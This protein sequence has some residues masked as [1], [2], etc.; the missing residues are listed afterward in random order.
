MSRRCIVLSAMLLACLGAGC[1]MTTTPPQSNL[2]PKQWT[3][4]QSDEQGTGFNS[5]H[6]SFA[7]P[8]LHK[9]VA[10]T[11]GDMA[12][13][14]PAVSLQNQIWV[15]T[16]NRNLI[17]YNADG[18]EA[19]R[20]LVDGAIVSSPAVDE[21]GRVFYLYQ[22]QQ[23]SDNS[24]VTYLEMYDPGDNSVRRN[25]N[26]PIFTT[27]AS[28]KIW[29]DY[30]FVPAG[31]T[32]YVF[33][34]WTMELVTQ[35][36]GCND[37]L[38]CGS[39]DGPF[40]LQFLA[41]LV[42]EP[43]SLLTG[44]CTSGSGF[45]HGES[46]N[47]RISNPSVSIVDNST[48]VGDVNIPIVIMA[49]DHCLTA[50]NF[51][52]HGINQSIPLQ[53]RW[54]QVIVPID[55]DHFGQ[56]VS[57]TTPAVL[58]GTQVVVGISDPDV[59]FIQS[60]DV[61]DGTFLWGHQA[62]AQAPPVAALRQIYVATP[63][64]LLVLDSN[65]AQV[66]ETP[67]EGIGGGISLSLDFAYVMTTKGLYS[68][69]LDPA[70][71]MSFDGE[72]L[73]GT[74]FGFTVPAIAQDGTVYLATPNGSVVAYENTPVGPFQF[75]R[76]RPPVTFASPTDGQAIG[77]AAGQ[78]LRVSLTGGDSGFTGDIAI[79]SDVDGLL[80]QFHVDGVTEASCT[81]TKPLTLGT[82]VLT[83]FA[84]DSDGGQQSA[85]VSVT[86][87]NHS[88]SVQITSPANHA[89]L[90]SQVTTALSAQVSDVDESIPDS[91]IAWT[92]DLQGALGTGRTLN[93]VLMDGTHVLTCTA[94]DEKGAIATASV[95][96]T[97][98]DPI[99]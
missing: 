14:S 25:F 83:A 74:H 58:D 70:K 71:P 30:V 99:P 16:L 6:T 55:C 4:L 42:V 27:T 84:T 38:T 54:N 34:R 29:S 36:S 62:Y 51:D 3:Q 90:S 20:R 66:S 24:I 81:T 52:P 95:T 57:M 80:C 97:V 5:V 77:Y 11:A 21:D 37:N 89:G 1:P 56:G 40:L 32:L 49:T 41:C 43:T 69:A 60:Y 9:W 82:Q 31:S 79:R 39:Y 96:V 46:A 10:N 2:N 47:F 44:G 68:Y 26:Q 18:T 78:T 48:I 87:I 59:G 35:A 92:S 61:S 76:L 28:P 50:F 88:P 85:Q 19:H 91:R 75:P 45:N 17:G 23:L 13:C 64:S 86:V 22:H 8:G 94:T 7:V 15:G 93:V 73:D 33:N 72:V 67:L 65:G 98:G 12:Y 63:N 53:V